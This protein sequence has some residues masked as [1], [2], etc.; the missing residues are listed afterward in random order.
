MKRTGT[1][2]GRGLP[3]VTIKLPAGSV[4]GLAERTGVSLA[5]EARTPSSR[6]G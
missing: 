5:Q 2:S 3:R 1:D 6:T 4:T